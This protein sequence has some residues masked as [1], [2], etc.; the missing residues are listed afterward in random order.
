MVRKTLRTEDLQQKENPRSIWLERGG[1]KKI[2]VKNCKK[3]SKGYILHLWGLVFFKVLCYWIRFQGCPASWNVIKSSRSGS[4][5]CMDILHR[6]SLGLHPNGF[7]LIQ[8]PLRV[9][10][11]L[12]LF[13]S[14]RECFQRSNTCSVKVTRLETDVWLFVKA[15]P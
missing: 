4:K 7:L 6:V 8:P 10:S 3:Y 15:L 14:V 1:K 11:Y 9:G 2:E 13:W 5:N 12:L